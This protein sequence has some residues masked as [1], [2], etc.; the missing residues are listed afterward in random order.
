M[1]LV[2]LFFIADISNSRKDKNGLSI[3]LTHQHLRTRGSGCTKSLKAHLFLHQM[4][5]LW[6][7]CLSLAGLSLDHGE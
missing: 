6:H 3:A 4:K 1:L 5:H 7:Y 2:L